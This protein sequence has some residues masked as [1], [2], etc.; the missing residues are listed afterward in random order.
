MKISSYEDMKRVFNSSSHAR[1]VK[2][3]RKISNY[4]RAMQNPD[5]SYSIGTV[6]GMGSDAYPYYFDA[7]LVVTKDNILRLRNIRPDHKLLDYFGLQANRVKTVK[8]KGMSFENLWPT[9][10]DVFWQSE[11]LEF[12]MVTRTSLNPDTSELKW[13][14]A[15]Q[16]VFNAWM[17]DLKM[18]FYTRARLDILITEE[19]APHFFDSARFGAYKFYSWGSKKLDNPMAVFEAIKFEDPKELQPFTER[20]SGLI[21][22]AG[23]KAVC[24]P[25]ERQVAEIDRIFATNRHR[26]QEQFGARQ[27]E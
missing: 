10:G 25:Y 8:R 17:Q 21:S 27:Y 26:L 9:R 7:A 6:R 24:F 13:D 1:K 22:R 20:M 12:N 11:P 14:K 19:T 15:K 3:T 2:G 23:T 16:K 18:Q 4:A 5:G